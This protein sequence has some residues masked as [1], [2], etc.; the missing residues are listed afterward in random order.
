M[1]LFGANECADLSTSS[2][3]TSELETLQKFD[4][5][6]VYSVNFI[7]VIDAEGKETQVVNFVV[8][9]DT[10]S[11]KLVRFYEKL[12]SGS[13]GTV[14][15]AAEKPGICIKTVLGS[16][17]EVELEKKGVQMTASCEE[18]CPARILPWDAKR[19]S[20]IKRDKELLVVGMPAFDG[21]LKLAYQMCPDEISKIARLVVEAAKALLLHNV[22]PC[23]IKEQNILVRTNGTNVTCIQ[24]ADFGSFV[25][26]FEG[27]TDGSEDGMTFASPPNLYRYDKDMR[28]KR[29]TEADLVWS[30]AVAMAVM[31]YGAT[32]SFHRLL[33]KSR[34]VPKSLQLLFTVEDTLRKRVV[35]KENMYVPTLRA[36]LE[37]DGILQNPQ[38][39]PLLAYVFDSYPNVSL[40]ALLAH[41]PTQEACTRKKL[42]F[43]H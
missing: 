43:S 24:L 17:E 37:K 5:L 16:A 25:R 3:H 18:V 12:S 40:D 35:S 2:C 20:D 11:F 32:F 41:I 36:H 6:E 31:V 39:G 14:W 28:F 21:T 9:R 19:L 10:R 34:G 26:F 23:D 38:V 22:F 30:I 7:D 27:K 29:H 15:K 33:D 13:F 1:S 8:L 42:N 4:L